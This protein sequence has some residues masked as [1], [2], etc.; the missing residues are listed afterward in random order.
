MFKNFIIKFETKNDEIKN[1]ATF[2][3]TF[4]IKASNNYKHSRYYI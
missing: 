4:P 1:A 2:T 3:N